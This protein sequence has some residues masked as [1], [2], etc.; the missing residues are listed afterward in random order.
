M[1]VSEGLQEWDAALLVAFPPTIGN[2]MSYIFYQF[3]YIDRAKASTIV[4]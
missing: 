2:R 1:S 3:N 4:V